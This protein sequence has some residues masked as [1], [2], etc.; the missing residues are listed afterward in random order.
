MKYL[1]PAMVG[2]IWSVSVFAAPPKAEL[3]SVKKIGDQAPHSAFTDL[4]FDRGQFFCAFREGR[5]HAST[6]GKIRVMSS[7]DGETWHSAALLSL[8][9]QDLRDAGLSITPDN[10]LMLVGGIASRNKDGEHAATGSFVS[11][12]DDGKTWTKPQRVSEPGHWLW[13]VTWH[14][15]KAYGISYSS[16]RA[17]SDPSLAATRLMVSDDGVAFRELVPHLFNEGWPTEA[18]LRFDDKGTMYCLQRRDGRPTPPSAFLGSSA[19]PYTEWKW[20]DLGKFVGGPNFIRLPSGQW[21]AAGRFFDDK[22]PSTKL[23]SL[24]VEKG[25]VE[26]ILTLPSGGDT[27][28]PGLVWHDGVLWMSY[29]SSH[30]GKTSVYLAKIAI[31]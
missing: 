10:R 19:P 2:A 9:G 3:I 24:D 17:S 6:D 16:S 28:Y 29:Y 8:E 30:E 14:D 15:R 1:F 23:A 12:S 21:F 22:K 5:S 4:L 31:E 18:T 25:T 11:F 7:V 27:S 26:P 20:R 13:R